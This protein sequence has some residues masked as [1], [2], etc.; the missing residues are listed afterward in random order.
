MVMQ[1]GEFEIYL[2]AARAEHERWRRPKIF[3]LVDGWAA[4]DDDLARST[5]T[6]RSTCPRVQELNRV[7]RRPAG[8]VAVAPVRTG[9]WWGASTGCAATT[10]TSVTT[11]TSTWRSRLRTSTTEESCH[12]V[13]HYARFDAFPPVAPGGPR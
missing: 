5:R 6:C 4:T 2:R 3:S 13:V 7:E 10:W 1:F 11:R 9:D 12:A 8:F